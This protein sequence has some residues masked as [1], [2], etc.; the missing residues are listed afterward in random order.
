VKLP[1]YAEHRAFCEVDG[2]ED[3]DAKSK[4]TKGDHHRYVKQLPNGDQL[5]TQVSHGSGEYRSPSLWSH[6]RRDQLKVT[7]DEFWNAVDN[8]IPPARE[9]AQP[10]KPA[11]EPIPLWLVGHLLRLVGLPMN[12]IEAMTLEEAWTAWNEWQM[13]P[14]DDLD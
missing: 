9:D 6:I 13:S 8:G 7:E 10:P 5:Y 12:E 2:W 3:K 11:G 1:T 4:K 14:K